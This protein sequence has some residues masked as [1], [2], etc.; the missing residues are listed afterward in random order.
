[1]EILEQQ[2]TKHISSKNY[3]LWLLISLLLGAMIGAAAGSFM[4]AQHYL[5]A[6]LWEQIP[7]LL[8]GLTPAYTFI[9]CVIGGVLIGV[10]RKYL[11]DEPQ[12]MHKIIQSLKSGEALPGI[13]TVPVG[14]ALSL[15]SLG[16][17]AALGPEA[18][19][20]G[21]SVGFSSWAREVIDRA[22]IKLNLTDLGKRRSKLPRIFAIASGFAIFILVAKPM[23]NLSY[24]YFPHKFS[25]VIDEIVIAIA[26][27]LLGLFLG[28]LFIKIGNRLNQI[29]IPVKSKPILIGLLGGAILGILGMV[30]PLILFS[31]QLGLSVLFEDGLRMGGT[32]LITVGLLKMLATKANTATGWKG[33]EFF[34]VMFASAAIGLG[35]SNLIPA[36]DPMVAIAGLMAATVTIVMD[37]IYI[38]L[39]IVLMFLPINLIIPMV[40]ASLVATVATKNFSL[41]SK[42]VAQNAGK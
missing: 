18:A 16:F 14:Y 24:K 22:A 30:S 38:A 15:T 4:Y 6:F 42:L 26:L 1:M 20:V 21:I 11:G 3:I 39:A 25:F 19:L 41:R 33:G 36:I 23:F 40:V 37:N 32:M 12:P 34:P 9:I 2:K 7:Q 35:V 28:K 8:G 31:G 27:G 29:L 13:K 10:G 17:G 5:N